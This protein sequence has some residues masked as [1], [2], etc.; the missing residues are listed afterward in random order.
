MQSARGIRKLSSKLLLVQVVFLA[1]ALG[2]IGLTLFVS[3]KLEGS[4]A[5]INDA[6]SLRMRERAAR[7]GGSVA[8]RSAPGQG[9]EVVLTLVAAD[10]QA[11]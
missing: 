6:G 1:V 4:A 5:A 9:T 7:A 10:R 11:A 8:V 3:W 2:S